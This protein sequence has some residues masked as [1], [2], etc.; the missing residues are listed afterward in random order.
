[1]VPGLFISCDTIEFCKLVDPQKRFSPAHFQD[2]FLAPNRDQLVI[3]LTILLSSRLD[4][5]YRVAA[6]RGSGEKGCCV[7]FGR[8]SS[9]SS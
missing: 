9:V 2:Q 5:E 6:S 7:G 1:M 8:L 4:P 3:P